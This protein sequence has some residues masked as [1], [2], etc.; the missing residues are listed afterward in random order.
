MEQKLCELQD[1]RDKAAHAACKP[2]S[3]KRGTIYGVYD[4]SSEASTRVA[5]PRCWS[6]TGAATCLSTA[7]RHSTR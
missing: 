3:D 7:P 5:W 1:M 6:A 2:I 4:L